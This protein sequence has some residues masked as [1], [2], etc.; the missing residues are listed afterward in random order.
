MDKGDA[1]QDHVLIEG[2]LYQYAGLLGEGADG[3]VVLAKSVLDSSL[4]A[5]KMP[6]SRSVAYPRTKTGY[7]DAVNKEARLLRKKGDLIGVCHEDKSGFDDAHN[8]FIGMRYIPGTPLSHHMASKKDLWG[9]QQYSTIVRRLSKNIEELH[10]IGITH[11]DL[12]A[13]NVLVLAVDSND[14][15]SEFEIIDFGRS[16]EIPPGGGS[17]ETVKLIMTDFY[18]FVD[19]GIRHFLADICREGVAYLKFNDVVNNIMHLRRDILYPERPVVL[20]LP[21]VRLLN[22]HLT[23]NIIRD[24]TFVAHGIVVGIP[25]GL[26]HKFSEIWKKVTEE[27]AFEVIVLRSQA[28]GP[29]YGQELFAKFLLYG[30]TIADVRFG[31]PGLERNAR[32]AWGPGV[33]YEAEES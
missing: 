9:Y 1:F 8:S 3:L 23:A 29:P 22:T 5:I 6:N 10:N 30:R 15:P 31:A 33:F 26:N 27:Y 12:H 11:Q 25:S 28:K 18:D 7:F 17:I 2:V 20:G 21:A 32:M 19:Y 16:Q 13:G 24:I 14:I 4:I